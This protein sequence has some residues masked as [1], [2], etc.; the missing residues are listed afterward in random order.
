MA[1]VKLKL[2]FKGTLWRCDWCGKTAIDRAA[3]CVP[4]KAG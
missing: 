3:L 2:A 4:V 1:I